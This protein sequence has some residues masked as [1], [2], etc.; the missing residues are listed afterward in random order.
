MSETAP[1][2][3]AD[4]EQMLAEAV[5]SVDPAAQEQAETKEPD[6]GAIKTTDPA[7]DVAKW[8]ALARKHETAAKT[9]AE[10]ARR[11]AE[12][13]DA[14]KTEQQRLQDRAQSAEKQLAALQ[15]QNARL[16]AA[17]VHGIPAE[18]IDLL[19]DGAEEQINE[20]AEL[21]AAK[22][23]A[24]APPAAPAS[25]PSTR[26]VESLK[27]GGAPAGGEQDPNAWLRQ[28]AGRT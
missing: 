14:Q 23:A 19:G 16:M 8:K 5:A 28:M 6:K 7:A 13:E 2:I 21:L 10:A 27:P 24:A 18:L 25:A 3:D 20:R 1:E 9:N 17:T 15:A 22:L 11:L 12:Y 26:P 4:A